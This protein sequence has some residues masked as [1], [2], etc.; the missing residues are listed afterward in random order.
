VSNSI[1]VPSRGDKFRHERGTMIITKIHKE[2]VYFKLVSEQG[3]Q[4]AFFVL[5]TTEFN[6]QHGSKI[7]Q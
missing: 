1:Q 4:D 2:T 7:I 3:P 6:I 5:Q